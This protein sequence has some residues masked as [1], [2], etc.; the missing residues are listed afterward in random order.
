VR[1]SEVPVDK[2]A[3]EEK[4]GAVVSIMRALLAAREPLAPGDGSVSV[5]LL[6]AISLIV[7]L[8]RESEFVAT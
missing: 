8:L 7:P 3:A 5:A 1:V 2:T 4:V 6:A